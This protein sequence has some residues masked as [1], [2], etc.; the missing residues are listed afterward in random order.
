MVVGIAAIQYHLRCELRPRKRKLAAEIVFPEQNVR[1]SF[2]FTSR[3]PG[4]DKGIRHIQKWI[5]PQRPP[6]EKQRYHR[7]AGVFQSPKKG[8]IIYIIVYNCLSIAFPLRIRV[9]AKD[10]DRH[11]RFVLELAIGT[12]RRP[13]SRRLHCG[14]NSVPDRSAAWEIGVAVAVALPGDHRAA[15][16]QSRRFSLGRRG[17]R[18]A[19]SSRREP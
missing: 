5:D 17:F 15:I 11:I 8:K 1:D 2:T 14:P 10:N 4:G 18:T 16:V 7:H 12:Q 3:Q 13:P 19:L 6:G 9:L